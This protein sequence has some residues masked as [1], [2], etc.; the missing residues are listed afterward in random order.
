MQT[1]WKNRLY[2]LLFNIKNHFHLYALESFYINSQVDRK[3][4]N[5]KLRKKVVS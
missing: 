4:L 1:R 2:R 3:R 5:I